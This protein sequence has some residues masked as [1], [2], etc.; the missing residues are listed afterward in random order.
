VKGKEDAKSIFKNVKNG[1][2]SLAEELTEENRE[3]ID[4]GQIYVL[5]KE[6]FLRFE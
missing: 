3:K 1:K 6:N 5:K 4:D 2:Y